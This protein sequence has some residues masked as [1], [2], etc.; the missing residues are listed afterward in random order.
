MA[1]TFKHAPIPF[2]PDKNQRFELEIAR[3]I[4]KHM[5]TIPIV[6]ITGSKY[7]IGHV[8]CNCELIRDEVMVKVKGTHTK[9]QDYVTKNQKEFQYKLVHLMI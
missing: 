4:K 6:H 1:L 7:L 9:F 8:K 3:Q 2:V 5:I